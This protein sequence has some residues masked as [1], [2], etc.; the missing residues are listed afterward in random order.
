MAK[1]RQPQEER[2]K[3]LSH[4]AVEQLGT[5]QLRDRS[6]YWFIPQMAWQA[7]H[8]ALSQGCP[9]AS[10]WSQELQWERDPGASWQC[11]SHVA[12][13]GP[14]A[15]PPYL[16]LFLQVFAREGNVPNIIIAVSGS[17]RFMSCLS[18]GLVGQPMGWL[19]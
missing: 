4:R 5:S 9:L 16:M 3:A 17:A 6:I 2:A 1:P 8:V 14:G 12:S 18:L 19:L 15:S 10:S 13:A 11:L 7:V